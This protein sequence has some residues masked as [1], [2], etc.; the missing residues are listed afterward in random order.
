[1]SNKFNKLDDKQQS[2]PQLANGNRA[3]H[4]PTLYYIKK[5]DGMTDEEYQQKSIIVNN[6]ITGYNNIA[7]QIA[8]T[9]VQLQELAKLKLFLA[10]DKGKKLKKEV[11]DIIQPSEAENRKLHNIVSDQRI[12]AMFN[13]Y[14]LSS[15][16]ESYSD[17][18]LSHGIETAMT[19]AGLATRDAIAEYNIPLKGVSDNKP[20]EK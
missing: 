19:V 16:A 13:L 12:Q 7:Q 14:T 6:L 10:S 4:A 3:D 17:S 2:R 5:T 20:E 8:T 15:V 18:L 11:A 9:K 1:M